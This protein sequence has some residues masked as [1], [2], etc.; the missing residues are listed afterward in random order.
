MPMPSIS[1]TTSTSLVSL[2]ISRCC[3]WICISLREF[4]RNMPRL[5]AIPNLSTNVIPSPQSQSC[6]S[7]RLFPMHLPYLWHSSFFPF[8]SFISSYFPIHFTSL[9]LCASVLLHMH[10]LVL[11]IS[12]RVFLPLTTFSL[13]LSLCISASI[14]Q[15][16]ITYHW[17]A[18]LL[19]YVCPYL[20]LADLRPF[21]FLFNHSI[22]VFVLLRSLA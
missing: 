1:C 12:F 16:P 8:P 17:S 4:P 2:Q 14:S 21:L 9:C 11:H 22:Y 7:L 5:H 19:W 20:Q 13:P 10:P 15:T 3:C 6:I 18:H